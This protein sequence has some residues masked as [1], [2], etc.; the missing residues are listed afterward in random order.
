MRYLLITFFVGSFIV[1]EAQEHGFPFGQVTYRELDI[2][3]YAQDTA[4]VALILDEFGEAYVDNN[5]DHNIIFEYH[6]KIKIL[7]QGGVSYGDFEIPLRKN[8]NGYKEKVLHVRASSFNIDNGSMRESKMDFK[9]VFTQDI[10]K[11][12]DVTKFAVPNVRVGSVIE[13]S[14]KVESPFFTNFHPWE[15]QAAIPK[16]NS[17]YWCLIP[18]NYNYTIALKGNLKL[19]KDESDLI[20]NCFTPGGVTAD[21]SR[22]KFGMKNIPAFVEE[23]YMTAKSNFLSAI[24]FEL[25]EI[26]RFDGRTDKIT[27]EWKDVDE[28]LRENSSFGVQVKRGKEIIDSKVESLIQGETDDLTK[29]QKIYDFIKDWYIWN[30]VYGIF[31]ESGI[32]KAFDAQTGNVSDINLSLV[33]ALKYAKLDADPMLLSTRRNG[34][35]TE[36]YPVLSEF[37][38][39]IAKLNIGDKVYLLDA[40]DKHHP[41]GLIPVRCLNGKGRV[42]NA[43]ASY[44]YNIK[45]PHKKRTVSVYTLNLENNGT[46]RGVV[47]LSYSGYDAVYMRKDIS[48]FANEQDYIND[49]VKSLP[50]VT[51]KKYELDN[52]EDLKKPVVLKMD[53]EIEPSNT[54][55][56]DNFLFNPVVNPS[57]EANPFK[58][59]QRLYPVDFGV[60]VEEV[61][62]L[63][64]QYPPDYVVEALPPKV[65][66]ALPQGGGQF[67]FEIQNME[68]KLSM[69]NSL[70]IT[71]PIYASLDYPYLKEL[72][73]HVVAAQE[74]ALVFKK[75]K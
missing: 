70:L 11:Y 63:N 6:A 62:I 30:E 2:K 12:L 20:R 37:D 61:T 46:L 41:F 24:N 25:M 50:G 68:N 74:T 18:A 23:D 55:D 3:A 9:K 40:T 4:A 53:I 64:L 21:C 38:Y 34:M 16:V 15:F 75:K 32:K 71:R 51:V 8:A 58:S 66:I 39:V 54:F 5:N 49:V 26:R 7:K 48:K 72:F 45:P 59:V 60:P 35:V 33:A 69:N 22:L 67:I 1:A 19:S 42:M 65:G 13:V 56:G 29:A 28:E 10:H 44:W 36:L 31:S 14:Y 17:E 27:K 57:W 43:K 52:P 73:N 47:Q